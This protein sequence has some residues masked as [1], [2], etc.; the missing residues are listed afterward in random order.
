[1]WYFFRGDYPIDLS[2]SWWSFNGL[3]PL[4]LAAL[5]I[6]AW[7][8]CV[9]L[10]VAKLVK[11]GVSDK[12]AACDVLKLGLRTSLR[13]G[14]AEEVIFRWL[15]PIGMIPILI[16]ANRLFG[17]S[18]EEGFIADFSRLFSDTAN[19]FTFGILK[20]ELVDAHWALGGAVIFANGLFRDG[21]KYQGIVGIL[22]SWFVGMGFFYMTFNYGLLSAIVVHALYD[23]VISIIVYLDTHY[24]TRNVKFVQ[25]R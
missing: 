19:F 24:D 23:A 22:N 15:L 13:A 3:R 4:L 12:I 20:P 6:L 10:L 14:L 16:G 21:H 11:H 17:G 25:H 5:L 9:H 1:M 7:P 8:T 2:E 18:G